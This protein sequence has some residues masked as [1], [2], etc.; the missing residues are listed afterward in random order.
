ML[1]T[2]LIPCL[3]IKNG[4]VVK[5]TNFVGLKD[6]GDPLE[7]AGKY[8]RENADELVFLDITATNDKRK[9]VMELASRLAKVIFIPFTVGG[10]ISSCEDAISIVYSGADKISINT[11][12]VKRPE[13]ISECAVR[14]GSQCVTVAIDAKRTPSGYKVFTNAGKNETDLEVVGWA[15]RCEEL[16]AGEI[17]LTVMDADGTRNGFD[18]VI[19]SEVSKAV[20]IPVIASGGAG[21]PE[22]FVDAVKIGRADAVLAAGIFHEGLY[23]LNDVKKHMRNN[24][25]PVRL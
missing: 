19:T 17:M 13:L 16:G 10:G 5:G 8:Y 20:G 9:T 4:R 23:T 25:V 15:K 24:G 1:T 3:D 14:L 12:A 21:K 22:H 2:R 11:A 18:N 7:L 6:S